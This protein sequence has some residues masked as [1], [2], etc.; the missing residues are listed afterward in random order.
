MN[1]CETTLLSL[2]ELT[3]PDLTEYTLRNL[4]K[5]LLWDETDLLS[6]DT[7][8]DC[9]ISDY[10]ILNSDGSPFD[11]SLFEDVRNSSDSG[12]N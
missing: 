9:G 12:N 5:S 10:Q 3:F 4:I 8:V 7:Q 11:T 2:A 1:P 6:K